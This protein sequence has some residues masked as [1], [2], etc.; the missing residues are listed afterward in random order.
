MKE[1]L[2]CSLKMSTPLLQM[3]KLKQ[4]QTLQ[5]G[6]AVNLLTINVN[7]EAVDM[8]SNTAPS[9]MPWIRVNSIQKRLN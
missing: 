8:D 7:I 9:F 1:P 4:R 6:F 5:L 3:V 2:H